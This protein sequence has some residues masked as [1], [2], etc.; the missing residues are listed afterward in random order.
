MSTDEWWLHG[1]QHSMLHSTCIDRR[2]HKWY[3]VTPS[4][5]IPDDGWIETRD[6]KFWM[7]K[8]ESSLQ[9]HHH[10]VI[11]SSSPLHH[12]QRHHRILDCQRPNSNSRF[13]QQI[14][15][16]WSKVLTRLK[17]IFLP[18]TI[19]EFSL[20]FRRGLPN[21]KRNIIEAQAT[22]SMGNRRLS[23]H[24]GKVIPLAVNERNCC[25]LLEAPNLLV[26]LLLASHL[27]SNFR[28]VSTAVERCI[29]LA[30][31]QL[32]TRGLVSYRLTYS[33]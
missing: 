23:N 27:R 20:P 33:L 25:S 17:Q 31:T 18:P 30:S 6:N 4:V 3:I 13:K 19:P 10:I 32:P 26:N 14:V 22:I 16:N 1:S 11:I 12:H 24:R 5:T 9:S 8:C 28:S 7:H 15:S 29:T 2:L 21:P